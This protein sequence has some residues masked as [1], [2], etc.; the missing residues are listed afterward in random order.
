VADLERTIAFYTRT[1]GFRVAVLWPEGRPTF[2]ILQRDGVGL[3]FF[4]AGVGEGEGRTPTPPGGADLYIEV[5][6]VLALH[7]EL[8]D[9][10]AVEWGP[11]VY[12]YGRREFAFQDPDGYLVIFTEPTDDAVTC[13]ED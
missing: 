12:F 2:C 3:G 5:E 4:V 8:K 1:L 9:K 11:E 10:V 6:N 7:A 13:A